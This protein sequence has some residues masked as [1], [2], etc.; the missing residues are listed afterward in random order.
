MASPLRRTRKAYGPGAVRDGLERFVTCRLQPKALGAGGDAVE[1]KVLAAQLATLSFVTPAHVGVDP[2]L[3]VGIR[4]R[5]A[6]TALQRATAYSCPLDIMRCAAAAC[7]HL[8]H[9]LEQHNAAFVPFAALCVLSARPPMLYSHLEYA[10]RFVHA[11]QLWDQQLG[12][13]LSI[14]R[15]AVQW[16]AIQDPSTLSVSS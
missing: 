8:S 12:G 15:A 4:W 11:E 9:V 10:N 2:S 16:V 6:H 7:A 1:D 5:A 14:V 3:C 13:G